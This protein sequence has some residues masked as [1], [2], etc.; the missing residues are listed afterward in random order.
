M[1]RAESWT[2]IQGQGIVTIDGVEQKVSAGE[3]I[4]INKEAKHI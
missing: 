4:K 3:S 2:I 1:K